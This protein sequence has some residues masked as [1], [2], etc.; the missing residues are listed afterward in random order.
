MA[1]S[2]CMCKGE[3]A[4]RSTRERTGLYFFGKLKE[5]FQCF[6][7]WLFF[8]HFGRLVVSSKTF[9]LALEERFAKAKMWKKKM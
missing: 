2:D 9:G 3:K 4:P 6:L 1:S 8:Q 7:C 5:D